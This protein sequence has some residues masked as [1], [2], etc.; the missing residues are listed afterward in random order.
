M[1]GYRMTKAAAAVNADNRPVEKLAACVRKNQLLKPAAAAF[2][3]WD[4][5]VAANIPPAAEDAFQRLGDWR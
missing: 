1:R 5:A 3:P 2:Q 4:P